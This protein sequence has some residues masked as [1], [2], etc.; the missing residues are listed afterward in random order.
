[1]NEQT[2]SG[3]VYNPEHVLEGLV[4]LSKQQNKFFVKSIFIGIF[5]VFLL[6]I[7]IMFMMFYIWMP[8]FQKQT[9]IQG[10]FETYKS[11]LTTQF[12][13]QANTLQTT[14]QKNFQQMYEQGQQGY[15]DLLGFLLQLQKDY[16]DKILTGQKREQLLQ[17]Q[18]NEQE[19]KWKSQLEESQQLLESLKTTIH[20]TQLERMTL[21]TNNN[22]L[23]QQIQAQNLAIESYKKTIEELQKKVDEKLSKEEL[24]SLRN[25][26]ENDD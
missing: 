17:N 10:E 14:Y 12:Q 18:L 3:L 16:E 23:Q 20:Q 25:D 13:E 26:L 9:N 5:L 1:M 15:K 2:P 6:I 24:E 21:E 8:Y 19:K 7:G 11:G 22:K 4:V